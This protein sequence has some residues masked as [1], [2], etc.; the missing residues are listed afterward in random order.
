MAAQIKTFGCRLNA[1][2]SE[3][4]R[5][6]LSDQPADNHNTINNDSNSDND[7]IVVVNTCAVTKQAEKQARTWIRKT[8]RSNPHA[9]IIVTGC[10]AQINPSDWGGMGEVNAVIGNQEKLQSKTWQNIHRTIHADVRDTQVLVSDIMQ[11]RAIAPHLL[12][13]FDHHSR[14][15]MQIQQGCDHRCTFCI[16]PYGRG[17]NRSL[18]ADDII[19]HCQHMTDQ[20]INEI[21]LTGVDICSWGRDLADPASPPVLGE[22]VRQIL[23]Q[24]PALPR[25]RLSSLDP[26]AMDEVLLDVLASEPR[27]M[28]HLHLSLQHGDGL[29]LKR[30]KRRHTPEAVADLVKRVRA[31]RPDVVFGADV[32]TGFPTETATA[33]GRSCAHI[34]ECDISWVHVFPF[35]PRE[36]TPAA[37]MP[38][39][40]PHVIKQR[41]REMRAL[42]DTQARRQRV[43]MLGCEDE[44]VMEAGGIAHSRGFARLRVRPAT[45][46]SLIAGKLYPVRI[47]RQL[48]QDNSDTLEAVALA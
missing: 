1:W 9:K 41:A 20:G 5:R 27:L 13:G 25:L 29:M 43:R 38:Q 24:V 32:I 40:P 44:V 26:A 33:H 42:A 16:I 7:S 21:V 8:R 17:G 11:A 34:A 12:S 2:E 22:L 35:S 37:R 47:A 4:I 48:P 18:P 10:A 14:A 19:T 31:L 3:V 46:T 6:H 23:K 30:M 36:G 15:F 45:P 28:P 39:L